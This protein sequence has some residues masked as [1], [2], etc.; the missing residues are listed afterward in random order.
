MAATPAA[1]QAPNLFDDLVPATEGGLLALPST[2]GGGNPILRDLQSEILLQD[3]V[4]FT[5]FFGRREDHFFQSTS[6]VEVGSASVSAFITSCSK[7]FSSN[8]HLRP[9]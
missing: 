4:A 7:S 5:I 6:L 2:S 8:G 1:V 3:D 9:I